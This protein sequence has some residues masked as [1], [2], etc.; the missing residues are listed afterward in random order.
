MASH[1]RRLS[2]VALEQFEAELDAL[3]IEVLNDIGERDAKHIRK[4][5]GIVQASAISGRG[6]LMFGVGP[7]SWIAGIIGLSLAKIL[8]NMEV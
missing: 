2:G 6:L 5:R 7:I 8:E 1:K 4:M 3:R